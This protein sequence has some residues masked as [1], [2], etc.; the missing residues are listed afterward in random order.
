LDRRDAGSWPGRLNQTVRPG[1]T[2][3]RLNIRKYQMPNKTNDPNHSLLDAIEALA[4]DARKLTGVLS[5]LLPTLPAGADHG[6]LHR[7][8]VAANDFRLAVE[9]SEPQVT[10]LRVR[11]SK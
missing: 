2:P 1:Y 3:F 8:F 9:H 10:E 6:A 7:L 5:V 4:R 11:L